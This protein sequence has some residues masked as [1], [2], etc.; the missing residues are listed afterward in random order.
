LKEYPGK[1]MAWTGAEGEKSLAE[2][3]L[4]LQTPPQIRQLQ[5][6]QGSHGSA[7][8]SDMWQAALVEDVHDD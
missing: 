3:C 6:L 2:A 7:E 5:K 4:F 8:M 1:S